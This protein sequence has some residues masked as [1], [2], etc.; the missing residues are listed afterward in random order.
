MPLS[1]LVGE[2]EY[3]PDSSYAEP[4]AP[5]SR[6]SSGAAAEAPPAPAAAAEP[7]READDHSPG[8]RAARHAPLL[9]RGS[10]TDF[11]EGPG[12]NE[13]PPDMH[14]DPS[15]DDLVRHPPLRPTRLDDS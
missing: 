6:R 11:D 10:H 12:P 5:S 7:P 3:T 9:P 8:N 1:Y 13:L 14:A 4:A 15:R 2:D